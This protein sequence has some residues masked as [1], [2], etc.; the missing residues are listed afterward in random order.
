MIFEGMLN[1]VFGM[2]VLLEVQ[3]TGQ[4]YVSSPV[5]VLTVLCGV[6]AFF[7]LLEGWTKWRL[8]NY[9]P[10]LI[11]IYAIPA[12]MS[13]TGILPNTSPVYDWLSSTVLP[14]FLVIM[15]LKVDIA[16][17]VRM[18]GRGIFVMLFGTAG[19]VLGAPIAY[20]LVRDKL[21]ES[22]DAWKAFGA[23]AGSWIGGTGNMAAVAEGLETSGQAFGLAVL[24]DNLVYIVWLPILLGSKNLHRVFNRFTRVDEKRIAM[25]ESAQIVRQA[26]Q[27]QIK[28][29][30]FLYLLALGLACTWLAGTIS[31]KLPEI[32][33]VLTTST[34]KILLVTTMGL[35]L[36]LTPARRIPASHELAMALV[37]IFVANMGAK[38][39]VSGLTGSAAWFILACYIWIAVHGAFCVLGAYLL[40][41]DIHSTAIA[42]AANIGGA[43]SAPVVAAHHNEKL[44]PASILMALIGYAIGNYGA[45]AAAWLCYWLSY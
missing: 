20:L 3:I 33:P 44:V 45:F 43:A 17:T 35:V 14:M 19:V 13:N 28:T 30:H 31:G 21:P 42:S 26:E 2:A 8:F 23:L 39:D 10:P 29:R 36:S 7:F 41:V 27:K 12:I 6:G 34:W 40:R 4:P 37:Y 18:M 22:L 25:L 5:G 24:G 32:K 38:A 16:S 1:T 9:F 15:L 11:F